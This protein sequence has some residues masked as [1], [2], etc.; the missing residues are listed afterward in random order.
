MAKI[1]GVYDDVAMRSE[2][3]CGGVPAVEA[4]FTNRPKPMDLNE[5]QHQ[6]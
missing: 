4:D 3:R 1:E 5:L 6:L 2:V